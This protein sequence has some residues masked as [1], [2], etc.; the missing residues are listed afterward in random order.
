MRPLHH[1]PTSSA[2][3]ETRRALERSF[4]SGSEFVAFV[5]SDDHSAGCSTCCGY[6]R[7]LL[8][9]RTALEQPANTSTPDADFTRRVCSR[10]PRTT[11]AT[12]LG[13][14]ALRVLPLACCTL[15]LLAL[16]SVWRG[17]VSPLPGTTL[18]STAP[19][20]ATSPQD[21]LLL[22]LAELGDASTPASP[23]SDDSPESAAASESTGGAATSDS[24][25]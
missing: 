13:T 5:A 17:S 2:C 7:R 21:E 12:E 23:N 24:W 19:A 16:W 3:R 6:A 14:A 4:T 8:A 20:V 18:A 11:P 22:L 15:L 10:L 25:P 1:H 9:L